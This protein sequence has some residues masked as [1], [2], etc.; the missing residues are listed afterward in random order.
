MSEGAAALPEILIV[1]H[2]LGG[3]TTRLAESVIA[4]ARTVAGVRVEAR[5][6]FD[7]TSEHLLAARAIVFGTAEHLGYMSGA[8]KD[9]F[10]RT[11]YELEGRIDARAYALFVKASTDGTGAIRGVERVARGWKLRAV[12]EPLLVVGS[13][14]ETHLAAAH[15]LGA[16]V[17]AGVELGIF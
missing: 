5:S 15:E 12:A 3:S 16:A 8:L 13:L 17:A 6:C 4:G 1:W 10:D 11:Y 9:L 2:S 7:T 14:D